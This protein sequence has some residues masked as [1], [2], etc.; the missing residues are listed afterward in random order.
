MKILVTGANGQ[1][2]YHIQQVFADHK[3]YLGT[4]SNFDITDR[5]TVMSQTTKFQPEVIIHCAAY[6]DVDRAEADRDQARTVNVDG[7]RYV[8]EAVKAIGATLVAIST[9]YVFAGDKS[10][11]YAETDPTGPKSYYGQTKLAGEQTIQQILSNYY[12]CRTG[13][14]YGGAKPTPNPNFS[15][16]L[17]KNF[18]SSMLE[19]G[20]HGATVEVVDDQI[21]APTY[22]ADLAE[23]I[24]TLL[25]SGKYG[26]YHV[27]NHGQTNWAE[28]AGYIFTKSRYSTTVKHIKT[29]DWV[30]SHPDSARRPAYSILGH[31]ALKQAGIPELRSWQKAI[32]DFLSNYA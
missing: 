27:S 12:I 11:P 22:A 30:K 26:V 2:G 32:D 8:A 4:S 25:S 18:V 29:A 7:S 9:D 16:T 21:G 3:L 14:L 6:T 17:H 5:S 20:R 19:A 23:T 15:Q 31:Q 10:S 24:K 13:W 28:F 1:L